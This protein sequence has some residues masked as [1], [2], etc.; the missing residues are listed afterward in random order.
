MSLCEVLEVH[1]K[2]FL[3]AIGIINTCRQWLRSHFAGESLDLPAGDFARLHQEITVLREA[4]RKLNA[5]VTV[6]SIE[7]LMKTME[8]GQPRDR[9]VHFD[10]MSVT[11]LQLHMSAAATRLQD[12]LDQYLMLL[13]RGDE[14]D[15]FTAHSPIFGEKVARQFPSLKYDIEE[16]GKCYALE[17]VRRAPS[18]VSDVWKVSSALWRGAL[19]FLIRQKDQ[20]GVGCSLSARSSVKSISGGRLLRTECLGMEGYSRSFTPLWPR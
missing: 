10:Q 13:I 5:Y 4:C 3:E 18:T 7:S 15:F 6:A 12:E 2:R 16:A 8:R 11:D 20:T 14:R 19:E 17:R 1:A 9:V